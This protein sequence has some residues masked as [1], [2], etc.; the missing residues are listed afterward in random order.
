MWK[1]TTLKNQMSFENNRLLYRWLVKL[2]SIG[3]SHYHDEICSQNYLIVW[4]M[5]SWNASDVPEWD[6]SFIFLLEA[7][8]DNQ[9]LR[10]RVFTAPTECAAFVPSSFT[11]VSEVLPTALPHAHTDI[12]FPFLS[13][14]CPVTW[15]RRWEYLVKEGVRAS[16]PR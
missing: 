15:Q 16:F 9:W 14:L 12:L 13:F 1:H 5:C 8:A 4:R 2:T 7:W 11:F 10:C 6:K 3:P